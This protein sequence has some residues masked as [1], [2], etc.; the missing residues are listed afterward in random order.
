MIAGLSNIVVK[1]NK[2]LD[3]I[4]TVFGFHF[5]FSVI[6]SGQ[7]LHFRWLVVNGAILLLTVLAGEYVC[8]RLEQLEIKFLDNLFIALGPNR[9]KRQK[10]KAPEKKDKQHRFTEMKDVFEV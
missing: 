3:F 5:L 10:T 1:A 8:I 2:V 4:G 7:I 6:Y 9:E